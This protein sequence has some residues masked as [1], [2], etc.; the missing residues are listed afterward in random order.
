[1]IKVKP[2]YVS[3]ELQRRE[4]NARLL[5]AVHAARRGFTTIISQKVIME[6]NLPRLPAGVFWH[7]TV[8]GACHHYFETAKTHQNRTV[9][10]CEEITNI[11]DVPENEEYAQT[12]FDPRTAELVDLYLAGSTLDTRVASHHA[13]G[14]IENVGN[15]RIELLRGRNREI[16]A[17][18]IEI[19]HNSIGRFVLL[20]SSFGIH[21][22]FYS[23]DW[24][25]DT[26][27]KMAE[28]LD[29]KRDY[30]DE[31]YQR[32]KIGIETA[33]NLIRR[34]RAEGHT[35][36]MRPHPH[37]NP[38]MWINL[39]RGIQGA[40]VDASGPVAPWL[41]ACDAVLQGNCTTGLEGVLA[42]KPVG[43]YLDHPDHTLSA[44]LIPPGGWRQAIIQ[45][46]EPSDAL[47][48]ELRKTIYGIDE[49][50]SENTLDAIER[51]DPPECTFEE[52]VRSRFAS[53]L[54]F[55]YNPSMAHRWPPV[56]YNACKQFVNQA[57]KVL[58]LG[59]VGILSPGPNLI[60]IAPIEA[61][62]EL[63][64]RYGEAPAPAP[65]D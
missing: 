57:A 20:N 26:F 40:W 9:A 61:V 8:T 34:L 11:R 44:F 14:K 49:P 59:N 63:T 25:R 52:L 43:N 10:I 45:A 27:N 38:Q 35:V 6:A 32:E 42:G 31:T 55:K 2:I 5:F 46:Q 47:V 53:V 17:P 62:D 48:E 56:S 37:E 13:F 58:D 28:R 30:F 60:M 65:V 18:Q 24:E 1:M 33:V 54:D 41:I 64:R 16:F 7:K 3:C 23:T 50:I 19:L 21:G 51:L 22:S 12:M 15:V 39:L 36:V 4:L 29:T